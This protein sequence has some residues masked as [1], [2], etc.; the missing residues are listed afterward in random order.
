MGYA[1]INSSNLA[2]LGLT[3]ATVFKP[4]VNLN[5]MQTVLQGNYERAANRHGQGQSALKA[6]LSSY[7]TGH[8]HRG[9]ANG[10]VHALYSKASR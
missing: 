6:A 5:A 1:Q 4:C 8:P 2:S 10:Y 7:N 3:V 9:L